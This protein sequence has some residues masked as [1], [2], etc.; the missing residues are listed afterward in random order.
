M[1]RA[2]QKS[3]KPI[4]PATPP[5]SPVYALAIV[6]T[7][8][9]GVAENSIV[10]L[11]IQGDRVVSKHVIPD[12]NHDRMEGALND[13]RHCATQLYRFGKWAQLVAGRGD[14]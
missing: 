9:M 10:A 4:E 12:S 5:A 13:F 3:E 14:E 8:R 2:Y 11:E 6:R 1:P 7:T